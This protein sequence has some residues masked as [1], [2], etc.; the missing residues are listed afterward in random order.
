[1]DNHRNPLDVRSAVPLLLDRGADINIVT[2]EFGTMLGQ[3]IYSGSTE[4]ATFLLEHGA[5]VL[6]V[7]GCYPSSGMFPSA[8]D[9]AHS[10]SSSVNPPLLL[11]LETA[12]RESGW[13]GS[14]ISRPPFPMPYTCESR[15]D[16]NNE[17]LPQS[18]I[19]FSATESRAGSYITPEQADVPCKNLDEDDVRDLGSYVVRNLS[20]RRIQWY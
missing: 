3:A 13:N 10:E 17:T 20:H 6:C 1:M 4:L 16:H 8:L 19:T 12:I 11:R 2:S 18:F 14:V 7:G 9:V 5:D 15:A